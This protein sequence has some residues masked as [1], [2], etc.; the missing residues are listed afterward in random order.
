[1]LKM[2]GMKIFTLFAEKFCLMKPMSGLFIK[3]LLFN[4]LI[5]YI[6]SNCS[7]KETSAILHMFYIL[8]IT[9]AQLIEC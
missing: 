4:V 8:Y 5:A 6:C 2:M 9:V 1:M 3:C 7:E